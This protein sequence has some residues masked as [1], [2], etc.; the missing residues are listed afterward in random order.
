MGG[1]EE[2]D[3]DEREEMEGAG[4]GDVEEAVE[5]VEGLRLPC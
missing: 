2:K 1:E 5:D 3:R 4:E